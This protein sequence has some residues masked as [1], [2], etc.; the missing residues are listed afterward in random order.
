MKFV[1]SSVELLGHLQSVSRVISSKNTLP[2]LDN[3]LFNL[4][5]NKL[6]L[7]ASDLES[8]FITSMQLENTSDA[9][10][11][12]IPARLLLDTLK[13]FPDQPLTFD[14][15]EETYSVV[16]ST[17][18]GQFTIMGQNGSDFPQIPAL[19]DEEKNSFEIGGANLLKGIT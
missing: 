19:R 11:I 2:I 17:E 6:E 5:E 8:T 12:A 16:I 1:V 10:S 4:S 13:E 14:V 3:I 15:N 9:G 7:T 18:N